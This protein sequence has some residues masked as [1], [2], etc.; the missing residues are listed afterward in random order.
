MKTANET[1]EARVQERTS[2]LQ[3]QIRL[4]E[5]ASRAKSDF[6]ANMSHELRTP[7]IAIIGFSE[8]MR[9]ESLTELHGGTLELESEVGVGTTVTVRFPSN[10]YRASLR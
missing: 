6:L 5:I 7:L 1:L 2:D 9:A 8:V 4:R 3:E 10:R